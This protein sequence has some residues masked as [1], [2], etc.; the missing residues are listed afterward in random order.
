MSSQ[1][2]VPAALTPEELAEIAQYEAIVKFSE[3]VLAG[4]HP[5]I[6]VPAIVSSYILSQ[7]R[8][9]SQCPSR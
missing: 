7:S 9:L 5:R 6:K 4:R 3:D 8:S 2:S 1:V